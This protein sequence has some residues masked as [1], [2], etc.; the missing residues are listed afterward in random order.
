MI[1]LLIKYSEYFFPFIPGKQQSV[2]EEHAAGPAGKPQGTHPAPAPG[3]APAAALSLQLRYRGC[4]E[5][6]G[7]RT[8]TTGSW[9][10]PPLHRNTD[11]AQS[12]NVLSS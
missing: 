4:D 8:V 3:P 7:W 9:A 11:W 12:L 6:P 5:R 10:Q 1:F 2:Q